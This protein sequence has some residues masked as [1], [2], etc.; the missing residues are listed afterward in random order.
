MVYVNLIHIAYKKK[1]TGTNVRINIMNAR[2][3]LG[4]YLNFKGN[5]P[6]KLT[7]NIA[8]SLDANCMSIRQ[9]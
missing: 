1:K 3:S 6:K 4:F 8:I 9:G 5:S 7:S 2:H